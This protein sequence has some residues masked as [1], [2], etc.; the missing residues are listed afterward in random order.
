MGVPCW[1]LPDTMITWLPLSRWYRAKTSAGRYAP[2]ICPMWA[3]PFT[4]G[5]ATPTKIRSVMS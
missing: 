5:H 4:Y 1:S 3:G 2:A